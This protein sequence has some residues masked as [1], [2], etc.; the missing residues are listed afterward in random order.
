MP[1]MIDH[2]ACLASAVGKGGLD[3]ATFARSLGALAPAVAQLAQQRQDGS[4]P[5]LQVPDQ[6]D[7]L[8]PLRDV[9]ATLMETCSHVAVLGTGGSSLGGQTLNAL[10]DR[11]FG[12]PAGRPK[13]IFLDNVDPDSFSAL[14]TS[15]DLSRLGVIAISKSGGT[16]ETLCQFAI[17]LHA[18]LREVDE[19]RL[20]ARVA[21]ITEPR[22]SSLK[23]LA[24]RFRLPVLDHNTGV[25]G[26]F[27]VLTNV[28][29]LPASLAGLDLEALRAGA[30]AVLDGTLSATTTEGAAPALGAAVSIGLQRANGIT[31]T[32]LMPYL[33]RLAHFG[34]WY[35][36]LWAESLGKDGKGTTPIRAMGT[37]DQHSQ[38][39]LYLAGPWDKMFSVLRMDTQGEGRRVDPELLDDPRLDYLAGRRMGDL[40]D[41]EARA[42]AD[43][44][45]RN[46]RP[47]RQILIDAVDEETLGGLFMH[48]ML[49]TI[50]AAHLL[51]VDPF[52][53]PAVEEG[54]VLARAYLERISP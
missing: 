22:E 12:P 29:L 54:K 4:L 26:R 45:I 1:F 13:L 14:F 52:D 30:A 36:Q 51:E 16:A 31:Q 6:S 9:A 17:L 50:L 43:T 41:A 5:L 33:D 35:R 15:V 46:G 34:L 37:V 42:T 10:V 28:G 49:E 11:G 53:Q 40:L 20:A 25:G 38:L 23:A 48:F 24:E 44:L 27:S 32:V 39:Q 7:D 18:L 3:E 47:T 21:V 8:G 19:S 2:S